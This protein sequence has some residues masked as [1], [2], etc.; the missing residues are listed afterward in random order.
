MTSKPFA[1]L[2]AR[3]NHAGS[4]RIAAAGRKDLAEMVLAELR[5]AVDISPERF[6]AAVGIDDLLPRDAQQELRLS[7]LRE[8]V[9]TLGGSMEIHLHFPHGDVQATAPVTR[10]R[11]TRRSA[12]KDPLNKKTRQRS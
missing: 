9:E 10:K 11:A 2:R 1:L 7:V 6:S 4:A 5:R 12:A 8:I 3:M